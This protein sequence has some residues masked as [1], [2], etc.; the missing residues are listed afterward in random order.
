MKF[1]QAFRGYNRREVNLELEDMNAQLID[2]VSSGKELKMQIGSL[3]E[4]NAELKDRIKEYQE[5]EKDLRDAFISGQQMANR[6]MGEATKKAEGIVSS[7]QVQ[8]E[9]LNEQI[10][11]L[12]D[13]KIELQMSV[14]RVMG[15]LVDAKNE[16]SPVK[17]ETWV[18]E[19]VTEV[20]G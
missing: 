14:D 5:I 17:P 10:R 3:K 18:D 1:K 15:Y 8:N 13:Q 6:V 16:L 12:T 7:A 9:T 11:A 2:A 19:F 20:K 4:Q